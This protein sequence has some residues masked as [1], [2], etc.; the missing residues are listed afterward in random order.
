M[1]DHITG[2]CLCGAVRYHGQRSPVDPFR[3]YCTDCQKLTG[4]GHSDMMPL[5]ADSF[6][7]EGEMRQWRMT[8]GSGQF[9]WAGFCGTCGCPLLR[10]ADRSP[11]RVYV[12]AASLDD[13]GLYRP[14]RHIYVEMALPWDPAPKA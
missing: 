8:G 13:P 10:C 1:S 2:G 14:E 11:E 4:A 9:T 6:E 3:C 7:V 5:L 12:H